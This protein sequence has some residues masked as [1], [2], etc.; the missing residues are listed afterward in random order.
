MEKLTGFVKFLVSHDFTF[1]AKI[2]MSGN[3][4]LREQAI[5]S[6]K[7]KNWSEAC[8]HYSELLKEEYQD[9]EDLSV[10]VCKDLV[11]YAYCM[12]RE[13]EPDL[14]AAWECLETAKRGYSLMKEEDVPPD[15]LADVYEFLAEIGVKNGAYE[16]ATN[17]Y[18]KIIDLTT[19]HPDL[20]WRVGL[21]A[22]YMT[23]I[24]L[25]AAGKYGDGVE[26]ASKA[27]EFLQ[28]A[29]GDNEKDARE[30][31]EIAQSI[32]IKRASLIQKRD[33]SK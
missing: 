30:L 21:N 9:E 14:S 18:A 28:K 5:N 15:G 13:E 12:L 2:I 23:T 29:K 31:D 33:Q 3:D 22:H 17:Q 27:L 20:S 7:Q 25:E 19:K 26:A 10:Q 24:C 8:E 6:R 11:D 1:P 32:I 16:E 4:Q